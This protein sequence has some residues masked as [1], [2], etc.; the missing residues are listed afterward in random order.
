[1]G[2][3]G[4]WHR[5]VVRRIVLVLVVLAAL[6]AS[7]APARA[8]GTVGW[9]G[10]AAKHHAKR[11][12]PG[13]VARPRPG[14]HAQTPAPAVPAGASAPSTPSAPASAPTALPASA[15][16]DLGALESALL[17]AVDGARAD[18]GLPGLAVGAGLEAAARAHT[19]DLLAAGA[20]THDFV[21]SSGSTPFPG[22]IG[23]Y[24][25]G[26][27]AGE[28]LA[29]GSPTLSPAEA[30]AMWLASP[31]HRANLLSPRFTTVGVALSAVG[32]TWIATADFGGC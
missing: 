16:A 11:D 8:I 13:H 2:P 19:Q 10:V 23:R 18:A 31:G 28:T 4:R 29:T 9:H 21:D 22:W 6:A 5:G 17:A 30:V 20:F 26:A 7:A 27:C 32:G 12:R 25:H 24:Y 14:G 1:M 15:V 3:G